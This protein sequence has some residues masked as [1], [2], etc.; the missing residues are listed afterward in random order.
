MSLVASVAIVPFRLVVFK[1]ASG[2]LPDLDRRCSPSAGKP[3]SALELAISALG[4]GGPRSRS[5]A[6][7]NR[8]G[9][10]SFVD[11]PVTANKTL[12]VPHGVGADAQGRLPALQGAARLR[13]A[14]PERLRLPGALDRG[15]RRAQLGLN[16][17]REIEEFGLEE[18]ARRC[19]DVVVWS[20][21]S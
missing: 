14:L 19:R 15:R 5:C 3:D 12:A 16:S 1:R 6:S 4:A 2:V 8:V 21:A 10:W 11:G 13:P 7:G 17:K 9:R 20:A 18:F